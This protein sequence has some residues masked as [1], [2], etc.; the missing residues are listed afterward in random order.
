VGTELLVR[1]DPE[2]QRAV[3]GQREAGALLARVRE[4]AGEEPFR[5]VLRAVRAWARARG[6]DANALGFPGGFTWALLT[7][8]ACVHAPD[9]LKSDPSALLEHV[10]ATYARWRWPE[11]VVL[12]EDAAS[13]QPQRRDVMPVPT[14]L[15]PVAN[16]ARN[17]SRSTLA[18]LRDEWA[19]GE[20]LTRRARSGAGTWAALFEPIDALSQFERF[21]LIEVRAESEEALAHCLGWLEGHLTGLVVALE[22][23]AAL[24][25]RPFPGLWRPRGTEETTRGFLLGLQGP[26]S[27][28]LEAAAERF[29]HAF[30]EWDR[31][32]EGS[33]LT[34]SEHPRETLAK[35]LEPVH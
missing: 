11:P 26:A 6:L 12:T 18:V 33:A 24:R 31:R 32:P 20:T 29:A 3:L 34:V 19:R 27:A 16:S 9:G 15:A 5:Q 8:H 28:T 25:A 13:Y 7:A 23:D 1:L 4:G 30:T 17:V 21:L 10:F 35:R 22:A 2:S 14:L